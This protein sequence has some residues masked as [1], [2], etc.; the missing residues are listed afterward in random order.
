MNGCFY[1]SN[2]GH[3]QQ[4][5]RGEKGQG[6]CFYPS[7][8]GHLQLLDHKRLAAGVVFTLQTKGIYNVFEMPIII[9]SDLLLFYFLFLPYHFLKIAILFIY[10]SLFRLTIFLLTF[11]YSLCKTAR[12]SS[13]RLPSSLQFVSLTFCS[14]NPFSMSLIISV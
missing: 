3:L 11:S 2:K 1:P 5:D 12:S 4:C 6:S 9:K 13:E 7:N 10:T 14:I 8:K